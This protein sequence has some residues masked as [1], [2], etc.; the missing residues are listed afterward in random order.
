MKVILYLNKIYLIL[1]NYK[2]PKTQKSKKVL[3]VYENKLSAVDSSTTV[4]Y[5][6]DV[7][8]K[9]GNLKSVLE[10]SNVPEEDV[11][12]ILG[13]C[14]RLPKRPLSLKCAWGGDIYIFGHQNLCSD[15]FFGIFS[16]VFRTAFINKCPV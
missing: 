5:P 14:R 15:N 3:I 2:D 13:A 1:T 4:S 9:I 12:Y 7:E 11:I 8:K 10:R 6:S 16:H